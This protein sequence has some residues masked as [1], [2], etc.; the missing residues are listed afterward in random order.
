MLFIRFPESI[1]LQGR[2]E[3]AILET[4]DLLY[5]CNDIINAGIPAL[6]TLMTKHI[7]HLIVLPL[8]LPA[9]RLMGDGAAVPLVSN[10]FLWVS[11]LC[12]HTAFYSSSHPS[13]VTLGLCTC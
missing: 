2:L 6:R 5:Y 12:K 11:S 1:Q 9:I 13:P 3:S 10:E 7:M 8:L 4:G